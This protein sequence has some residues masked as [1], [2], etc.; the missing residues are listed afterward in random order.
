M[1][2]PL[3]PPIMPPS[4]DE[5]E[6]QRA[7]FRQQEAGHYLVLRQELLAANSWRTGLMIGGLIFCTVVP[8]VV[9]ALEHSAR[10]GELA[11]ASLTGRPASPAGIS[12]AAWAFGL[13]IA[14]LIM[15]GLQSVRAAVL[16]MHVDQTRR[17]LNR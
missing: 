1:Q 10:E 13:G 2:K 16:H 11:M 4:L 3:G 5:G 8:V 17:E 15:S 6:L 14:L 12:G 7:K 9:A